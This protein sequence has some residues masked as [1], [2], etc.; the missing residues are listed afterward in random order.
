MS[1]RPDWDTTFINLAA[2]WSRRSTCPR[3]KVGCVVVDSEH[4]VVAAGYNGAPRNLPHC[5]DVGCDLESNHCIRAVHSE[6]NAIAQAARTGVSLKN[7]TLYCTHL[8]CQRCALVI[9]QVGITKVKYAIDYYSGSKTRTIEVFHMINAEWVN[10]HTIMTE[11]G[12]FL[13]H[14][15]RNVW[16][17]YQ[18]LD[19]KEAAKILEEYSVDP[20]S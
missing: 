8:P 12:R 20:N 10:N 3:L 13:T 9:R 19:D 14:V 11:D 5:E 4:S 6:M 15:G 2:E 1:D 7:T 18:L 16:D 17:T